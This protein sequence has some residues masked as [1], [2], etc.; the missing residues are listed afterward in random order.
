MNAILEHLMAQMPNQENNQMDGHD[1]GSHK[2]QTKLLNGN[3]SNRCISK[4]ITAVT[5]VTGQFIW[6]KCHIVI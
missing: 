5:H 3:I 4:L 1:Y 6:D 2:A